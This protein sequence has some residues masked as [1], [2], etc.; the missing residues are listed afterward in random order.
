MWLTACLWQMFVDICRKL[1]ICLLESAWK[2]ISRSELNANLVYDYSSW[3]PHIH[4]TQIYLSKV[5]HIFLITLLSECTAITPAKL[6]SN[7][8]NIHSEDWKFK[9]WRQFHKST[10]ESIGGNFPCDS[11][12]K[13]KKSFRVKCHVWNSPGW[14]GPCE[15]LLQ[16]RK[17]DQQRSNFL[18]SRSLGGDEKNILEES[19]FCYDSSVT[20]MRLI[21]WGCDGGWCWRMIEH[22][23]LGQTNKL[24]YIVQCFLFNYYLYSPADGGLR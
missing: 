8:V 13:A 9:G 19:I 18:L 15:F 14:G 17:S 5:L 6:F 7:S 24:W 20:I 4:K 23:Y 1:A 2:I 16:Q 10:T 11:L 12:G 3:W 21:V 22:H